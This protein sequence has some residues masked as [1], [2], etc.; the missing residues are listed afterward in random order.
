V[1]LDPDK[2]SLTSYDPHKNRLTIPYENASAPARKCWIIW[3]CLYASFDVDKLGKVQANAAAEAAVIGMALYARKICQT[4]DQLIVDLPHKSGILKLAW[5]MAAEV[6]TLHGTPPS[7][8]A[9]H[10]AIATDP[11]FGGKTITL[12]GV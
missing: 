6:E 12:D 4:V 2:R 8:D 9:L 1:F 11:T 10:H 5:N 3:A 7:W